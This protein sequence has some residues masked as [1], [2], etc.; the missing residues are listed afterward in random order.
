MDIQVV[1]GYR[2]LWGFIGDREEEERLM[3]EKI[4]GWAESVETLARVSHKQ[5]QY[6]Y[7]GLQKSLQKEWAFVQ[8]VTPGI[9]DAFGPAEKAL[10]E[11]FMPALF[12]GLRERA[13][14]RGVTHLPVKQAG[15]DIPDPTQTAPEKWIASCVNTGHLV[16]AL[17]GQVELHTVEQSTCLREGQTAVRQRRQWRA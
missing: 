4:T 5:P 2:Y 9:G 11:N 17:R 15:L 8:R 10:Q 3:S 6:S 7:A 14:E 1:T 16:A 12:E 13:S